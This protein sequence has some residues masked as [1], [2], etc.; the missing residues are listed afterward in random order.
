MFPEGTGQ[1]HRDSK[2]DAFKCSD[3]RGAGTNLNPLF[4]II[5]PGKPQNLSDATLKELPAKSYH[6]VDFMTEK[7]KTYEIEMRAGEKIK[8]ERM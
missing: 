4:G 5:D 8:P 1:T 6:T 2:I 7:G 3:K